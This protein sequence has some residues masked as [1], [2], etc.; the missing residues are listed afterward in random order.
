[1]PYRLLKVGEHIRVGDQ[2]RYRGKWR[3]FV[4][5]HFAVGARINKLGEKLPPQKELPKGLCPAPEGFEGSRYWRPKNSWC[6]CQV[7]GYRR[8]IP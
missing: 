4:E 7:G 8:K 2:V 3:T 1:M 5:G 6:P